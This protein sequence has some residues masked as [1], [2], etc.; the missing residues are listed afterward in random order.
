MPPMPLE[1]QHRMD[2]N[3][4]GESVDVVIKR[5]AHGRGTA[6]HN[7]QTAITWSATSKGLSY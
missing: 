4:L 1:W 7:L 3:L 6:K 2:L 5:I